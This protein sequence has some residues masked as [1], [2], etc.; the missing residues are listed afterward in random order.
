M[1]PLSA[2]G[3]IGKRLILPDQAVFFML[4]AIRKHSTGIVVKGFLGLLVIS[5]AVWG[6]GDIFSGGG[7]TTSV[8]LV[9]GVKIPPDQFNTEFQREMTRLAPVF[10]DRFDRDQARAIGL[11]EQVLERMITR[12]LYGLGAD[13][14]GIVIS[15]N[16]VAAEIRGD[17]SF[18]GVL[19]EFDRNRFRQILSSVGMSEQRYGSIVREDLARAQFLKSVFAGG[20]APKT[21]VEAV[22]RHRREQRIAEFIKIADLT[23]TGIAEPDAA[24]LEE[25]HRGNTARFMAPGYRA[26]TVVTIDAE[27][28]AKEIAVSETQLTEAFEQR[29]DEFNQPQRRR[30]RQML[31]N[32]EDKA[33]KARQRLA[34]GAGFAEVA[35]DM[36]GMD[37]DA[38]DIGAMTRGQLLPE[39]AETVFTLSEDGVGGPL[40]SPLGW[41]LIQVVGI[42]KG[43]QRTLAEARQE[44]TQDIAREKAVDSLFSLANNLE[45]ELGGGATLEE[46]ASRL[47]LKLIKI[48]AIDA[49]GRD[50]AG[51]KVKGL[52]T[53]PFMETAFAMSENSESPLTEAGAD[54]Y[55]IVRVDRVVAPAPRPIDAVK[56][57]ITA[58][59]KAEKRAEAAEKMAQNFLERLNGG[60]ELATIAAESG[61]R[62]TTT[63]AFTRFGEGAPA[64]LPKDL[65][66]G[67]FAANPGEALRAKGGD[68]HFVAR[69][70]EVRASYPASDPAGVE[71]LGKELAQSLREDVLAQLAVALQKRFPVT[72]NRQAIDQLF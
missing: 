59:W 35:K 63:E 36:A 2:L 51:V 21:L 9:G 60:A 20:E 57:E 52:P 27:E 22:Y 19:G 70:K 30:L 67:L 28:L 72:V 56:T 11:T 55:F 26:L 24:A 13:D 62:V 33:K 29:Q 43:G 47:D 8:A 12:L 34:G 71:A 39:L 10:G 44:L 53:G 23:M 25:F 1:M 45:D 32:D 37:A 4:E 7:A 66:A 49:Q 17:P 5:F 18:R 40:K 42:E 50:A 16:L 48:D 64:E 15:D 41:H 61:R 3:G 6:I 58:A 14:L 38:L 54:G 31:F 69:L 68:G 46:A 65:I